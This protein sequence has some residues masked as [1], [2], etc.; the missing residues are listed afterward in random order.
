MTNIENLLLSDLFTIYLTFSGILLSLITLLYSFINGKRSEIELCAEAIKSGI[1]DPMM[2]KRQRNLAQQIK[3]LSRLNNKFFVLILL[4]LAA[5]II[6]WVSIRFIPYNYHS[7]ILFLLVFIS[8]IIGFLT[9]KTMWKLYLQY[10]D[11]IKI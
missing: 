9:V 5:C 3:Q 10:K 11:D 1:K 4:S 6:S 2:K 8:I 7:G